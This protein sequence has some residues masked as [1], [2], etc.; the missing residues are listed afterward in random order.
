MTILITL[1]TIAI[2]LMI[3]IILLPWLIWRFFNFRARKNLHY[4]Q[5][6]ILYLLNQMGYPRDFHSPEDFAQQIDKRFGTNL[7][8]FTKV[9]QK[10]K[11]SHTAPSQQEIDQAAAT[12]KPF[13]KAVKAHIP[14]KKRVVLFLNF[15]HPLH[16]FIKNH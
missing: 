4:K 16:F 15:Y 8:L 12:Y 10:E 7:S 2:V 11:Y 6:A 5:R 13:I 14:W 3:L 1:A 9:Y